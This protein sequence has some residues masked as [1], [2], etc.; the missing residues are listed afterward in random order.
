MFENLEEQKEAIRAM[1]FM[2]AR[3][4]EVGRNEPDVFHSLRVGLAGVNLHQVVTGFLHDVVEDTKCTLKEIEES[5]GK[6]IAEKVDLLTHH[7]DEFY[8]V[9]ISRIANSDDKDAK[10]VKLNDIEDNIKR[11]YSSSL[12]CLVAKHLK[13]YEVILGSFHFEDLPDRRA[14]LKSWKERIF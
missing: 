3:I 8:D 11:G 4:S 10:I 2:Q 14:F 5:F 12:P 7:H 13:A 6:E 1:K 9:Y